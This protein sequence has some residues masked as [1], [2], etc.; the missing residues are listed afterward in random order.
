MATLPLQSLPLIGLLEQDF[1]TQ[2]PPLSSG[3]NR[4]HLRNKFNQVIMCIFSN[5]E[6]SHEKGPVTLLISVSCMILAIL[7]DSYAPDYRCSVANVH[8]IPM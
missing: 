8:N 2:S 3:L 7:P 1:S 5:I 6:P 4:P